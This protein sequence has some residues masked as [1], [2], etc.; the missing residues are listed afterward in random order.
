MIEVVSLACTLADACEHRVTAMILGDG[1]NQFLD[2]DGLA[3][4]C[5]AEEP[6]FSTAGIGRKEIDHLDT[7]DQHLRLCCLI[8]E[9]WRL[10][11]DGT[12]CNS[13]DWAGFIHRLANDVDD[14]S[15]GS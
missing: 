8:D 14:T 5:A 10:L 7:G 13:F 3:Y 1:V 9:G 11:M 4:A 15:E 6:N 2:G 12:A